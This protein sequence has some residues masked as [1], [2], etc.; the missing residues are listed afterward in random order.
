VSFPYV[1]PEPALVK[2]SFLYINGSKRPFFVTARLIHADD[3]DTIENVQE[4]WRDRIVRHTPC[5]GG[6][7]GGGGGGGQLGCELVGV[8]VM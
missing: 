4:R 7:G 3:T 2:S 8:T 5:A 6:G 1:C